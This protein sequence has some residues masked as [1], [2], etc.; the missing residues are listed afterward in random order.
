MSFAGTNVDI[1]GFDP[2][3]LGLVESLEA[4][5]AGAGE[6][7]AVLLG[8]GG[9]GGA[10]EGDAAGAERGAVAGVG[11]VSRLDGLDAKQAVDLGAEDVLVAEADGAAVDDEA[12]VAGVVDLGAQGPGGGEGRRRW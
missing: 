1:V 4:E 10:G 6:G 5:R 8:E 7:G 12:E 2:H 9:E 3:L 11:A